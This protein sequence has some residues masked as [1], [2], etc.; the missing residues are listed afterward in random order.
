MRLV[1]AVIVLVDTVLV[2]G[3]QPGP[4]VPTQVKVA[5]G[6]SSV[7]LAI[8]ELVAE[9]RAFRA[10]PTSRHCGCLGVQMWFGFPQG[11]LTRRTSLKR[12]GWWR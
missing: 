9:K 12:R 2:R 4:A 1:R 5:A 6:I 7:A 11:Q 3:L 10:S 8:L